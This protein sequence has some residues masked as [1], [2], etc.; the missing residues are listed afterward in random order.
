MKRMI[1]NYLLF[2]GVGSLLVN[3]GYAG[4]SLWT[5]SAPNPAIITV[6]GGGTATV[7]Y[8]V[9]SQTPRPKSLVIFSHASTPGLTVSAC[10]LSGVGSTCQLTVTINGDEISDDGFNAGPYMCQA[11]SDGTPNISQCYQPIPANRLNVTKKYNRWHK[12]IGE[13]E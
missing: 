10:N 1:L 8:T 4:S 11:N 12:F 7:T 3:T 13:C 9:T 2:M 5:Y 6:S